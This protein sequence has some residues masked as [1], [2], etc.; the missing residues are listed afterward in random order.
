MNARNRI[1]TI[2]FGTETPGGKIFDIFLI[3]VILCSITVVMLDSV[4]SI[5]ARWGAALN[6][7]E[8]FF[9]IL[10]TVEYILRLYS[11]RYRLRYAA[12]FFGLVDFVAVAPTYLGLLI[13]GTHYILTVRLLRLLRIFRVL[14]LTAY[15]KEVNL[16]TEAL[17]A[18]GRRIVVFLFFVLTLVV[19]L[20]AAMYVVE[21]PQAGFTS[22]PRSVYWAIVTLTTVGYGDISPKTELGQTI[23]ALIM[24]MGYSL[25]VVP[26]GF[27]SIAASM[28]RQADKDDRKC[29]ACGLQGH[30]ADARFCRR[31]GARL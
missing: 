5:S 12:S 4:N 21:T 19:M 30:D 23:A 3:I 25:I 20:G 13:P 14:K 6:W 26:T 11:A 15:V 22:I 9:T 10:F 31:C 24:I 2:L 7:L 28:G 1:R 27:I 17:R 16:L 29:P 18:S 8:W